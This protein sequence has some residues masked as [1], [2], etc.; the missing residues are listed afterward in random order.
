MVELAVNDFVQIYWSVNHANIQIE[1]E[2][3]AEH[4]VVPSVIVT[5]NQVG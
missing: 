2:A 1:H 3:A 4:P 5:M